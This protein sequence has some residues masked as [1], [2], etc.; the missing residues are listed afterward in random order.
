MADNSSL[1][2]HTCPKCGDASFASQR[3]LSVHLHSCQVLFAPMVDE[4]FPKRTRAHHTLAQRA[5]QIFKSIQRPHLSGNQPNINRLSVNTFVSSTVTS[6]VTNANID[7]DSDNDDDNGVDFGTSSDFDIFN[8]STDPYSFRQNLNPPL[9]IKFGIHLQ[10]I[11]SSH[12]GVDLKL[13]DEIIDLIKYHASTQATDFTNNKLYHRQELTTTVAKLYN[14]TELQPTLHNVTL[15]DSSVVSVPVF[16]VKAVI[17]SMLHD[18][19]LMQPHNFASGYDIFSG[20]MTDKNNPYLNEIHT[21]ELWNTA[22]NHYCGGNDNAF[23][24]A[25]ICFY[26]KTHTD[27]YGSLSCAPFIMTFSFFN[28]YARTREDFYGVLGYI[29]NLSYGSGKSNS[30]EPREKLND[31]HRCLKLITDQI[32]ELSDGF[33]TIVLGQQVTIK[34]WIHFI[35]G[36]TSGHNNL[37]GQFNSSNSTYPYRDCHCL[38]TQM[39]DPIPQC[40]LITVA[41]VNCARSN[42]CLADLG[43]HCIDNAFEKVPFGDLEHGIFGCVP[44]EMLHVSGNGIMQY[45]LD[46]INEIISSGN[47]KRSTLHRLD[48]LH[49]NLVKDASRQSE[50]DMPR[51]SDRNGVTDGTKMSAS[52]RV[53]N[54]F[55]VL[56]A[57]HTDV[58]KEIFS[59]G[60]NASGIT[61]QQMKECIKLQ[62]GFE[63]WVNDSNLIAEVESA[64]SLVA[65]LIS[66]I[67]SSFPRSGGNQWCIPKIHSLSKMVHYMKK[68]GKAKNFSG[69][70][71]ERVLKS[72]VKDNAQQTQRRVN[73]FASQCATREYESFVLQYAFDDLSDLLG[74]SHY[75]TDNKMAEVTFT[76]GKYTMYFSSTDS[77]GRGDCKVCWYDCKKNNNGGV[78]IHEMVSHAIRTFAMSHKWTTQFVV[79]GFT[80]AKL[81]VNGQDENILFHANPHVYGS[82]RYHF[83][84]VNFM[85]DEDNENT[86]PARILSF[87]KFTT[88]DFPSP[89]GET[90][91]V[92]AIVH[93]S[94]EYI[95]WDALDTSFIKAF[96]L[97]NMNRC[98]YIINV[99]NICDPLFV[100]P[101][102]GKDGLHF[103]CCLPYRRWGNYFRHKLN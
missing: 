94:S 14:L 13:Y 12:R 51:M 22:C 85:D 38:L 8:E 53:G 21:G 70:V 103:L 57:L 16:N 40:K 29:P 86:C 99:N 44:A 7:N 71:G 62:L 10:H 59:E 20:R 36:D 48:I 55:L 87:V 25:L 37:V 65:E 102:Y 69:Q 82:E 95:S 15:S 30:K 76:S 2:S 91:A 98:L 61:L 24:L 46:V 79:E 67:Q 33:D 72:I 92:Y 83:C 58:G 63:K 89:D 19:R 56:C 9:G 90:N 11:L 23:P 68:F 81:P 78:V 66:R 5:E 32:C 52:E 3:A 50:K 84:M 74:N 4:P 49:Q 54:F 97:G 31:E 75:R 28:E 64:T 77:R 100:C 80:S 39:S 60:C 45:Q 101:N 17:L 96:T 18:K 27:L 88:E 42:G 35:A 1:T 6:A 47:N 26:D 41:G 93:T 34:P 43:L 73:V